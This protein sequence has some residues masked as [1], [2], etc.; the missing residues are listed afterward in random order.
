[1]L[2]TDRPMFTPWIV[3][4][5]RPKPSLW[6]TDEPRDRSG[7]ARR[8]PAPLRPGVSVRGPDVRVSLSPS[9]TRGSGRLDCLPPR[10]FS[11]ASNNPAPPPSGR[12]SRRGRFPLP[13]SASS[14]GSDTAGRAVTADVRGPT[15][16]HVG[17]EERRYSG[18]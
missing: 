4:G 6:Q 10:V 3:D 11:C 5:F 8:S 15:L 17:G 2:E 1:M 12:D 14:V 9:E 7:T 13:P 18:E 16:V